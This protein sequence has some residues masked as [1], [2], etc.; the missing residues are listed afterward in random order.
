MSSQQ[1]TTNSETE[2]QA[3]GEQCGLE[4]Q[5]YLTDKC[6]LVLLD[7]DL[8]TGKTQFVKG[9][10][11]ALGVEQ[12][13]VSPTYTYIRPYPM[14][15][16][17]FVHVDAWR[18]ESQLDFDSTGVKNYL[19]PGNMVIVEWPKQYL[20]SKLSNPELKVIFIQIQE[21]SENSRKFDIN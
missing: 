4:W 5:Q 1:I 21:V 10:A 17:E 12:Q 6:V 8:G 18:I 11:K 14:K 7:G 2:T 3:L 15:Q 16:G 9:L 13:I 20:E 19:K